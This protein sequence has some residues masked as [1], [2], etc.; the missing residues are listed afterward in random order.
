MQDQINLAIKDLVKEIMN[1]LDMSS[2]KEKEGKQ[3]PTFVAFNLSITLF[4]CFEIHFI[5]LLHL[6][7]Q[8]TR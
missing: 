2:L 5:A 7:F 6:V 4:I 8:I 3:K 1:Y